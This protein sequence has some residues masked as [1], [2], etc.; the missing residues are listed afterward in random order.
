MPSAS[1]IVRNSM[2]LFVGLAL[3]LPASAQNAPR[4]RTPEVPIGKVNVV[5]L[6][7]VTPMLWRVTSSDLGMKA[8]DL[9][10]AFDGQPVTSIET[11]EDL[12]HSKN[13]QRIMLRIDFVRD[14]VV[15]QNIGPVAALNLGFRRAGNKPQ[16][17]GGYQAV[18]VEFSEELLRKPV[19]RSMNGLEL[20][21]VKPGSVASAAGMQKGDVL[22]TMNGKPIGKMNSDDILLPPPV[23]EGGTIHFVYL[24]EGKWQEGSGALVRIR[25]GLSR[26]LLLGLSG[27]SRIV[28]LPTDDLPVAGEAAPTSPVLISPAPSGQ[29]D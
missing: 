17:G 28:Q 2:H 24:R 3:L 22:I 6:T 4:F 14:G 21:S 20:T 27:K 5:R 11:F 13:Q 10:F 12:F 9:V 16:W 23:G 26:V 15:H 7:S 18:T 29:P 8:G 1:R 19:I 25:A